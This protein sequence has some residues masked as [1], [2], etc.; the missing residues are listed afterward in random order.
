VRE[1]SQRVTIPLSRHLLNL[2]KGEK[3][4]LNICKGL[5]LTH[6][7]GAC[8]QRKDL[9][10][11]VLNLRVLKFKRLVMHVAFSEVF[12][13]TGEVLMLIMRF[14]EVFSVNCEVFM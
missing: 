2:E 6:F 9:R 8:H 11:R 1:S 12:D 13:V 3:R 14:V 5:P 7:N 4:A 10:P